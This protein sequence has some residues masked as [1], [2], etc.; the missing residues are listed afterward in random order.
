MPESG[1]ISRIMREKVRTPTVLVVDDE[2]LIRWSLSEGLTE[3]EAWRS[4]E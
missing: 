1:E 4:C 2:P 3:G